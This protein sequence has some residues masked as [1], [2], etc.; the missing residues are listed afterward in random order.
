[1]STKALL[2][3]SYTNVST[4][5]AGEWNELNMVPSYI[6]GIKT[7]KILEEM[8]SDKLAALISGV[9]TP[10]ARARLFKFALQTLN[11]PDPNIDSS[12]LQ[13]FYEM[14]H[15]E[16]RGLLAVMALYPDRISFS[17]PITMSVNGGL[18]DIASA[19]G[20]ML[21]DDKDLWSNQLQLAKD[22]D[23]QPFVQLIY[24]RKHLV[25]GTSPMTGVFTGVDYSQIGADAGEVQWFR[26]GR[27]EDPTP[28]LNPEQ[29]QKLYL[30]IKNLNSH[31]DDF[32]TNINAQRG[33]KKRMEL[34][35]FKGM[36]RKWE[37][38]LRRKGGQLRDKG[39]VAQ[40]PNLEYP[41]S[42]LFESS[43]PVYLK[44]DFTFTYDNDGDY[45]LVGDVQ[46]LLSDD[47]FVVGW[48]EAADA[49]PKL[50]ES[51]VFYLKIDNLAT[52]GA[53]YF[54]LPLSEIGLDIFKNS[55][56]GLLGYGDNCNTRLSA[57]LN[58]AGSLAVS[59]VVEI[60]GQ[61]VELN[62]REYAVKWMTEQ[63]KVI[64][65]PNF[66]SENWKNYYLYTE[67]TS[68]AAQQFQAIFK[69]K[70]EFLRN[71]RGDFFTS[72]YQPAADEDNAPQVRQ[73]I[74]Y[75]AGQGEELHKY[76]IYAM[77]LAP[78][79]LSVTV[80]DNGKDAHAGYL[81]L[82]PQVVNDRTSLDAQGEAVVGIDFG[83]NNM[84]VYY[85]VDDGQ[86]EPI[87]FENYRTMLVGA[88]SRDL[89][90][91]AENHE[92]LFFSNYPTDNGQAK[93][94]LHEHDSRYNSY[95]ESEEVAGGVPVS[96]PNV[97]VKEMDERTIT[98]QAGTLHYNMKWLNDDKGLQ[99]KRAFLKSLWL[100]TCAY[101]YTKRLKPKQIVWSYPGAMMEAD[102]NE[103]AN[104][105]EELCKVT[106]I[107]GCRP[108]LPETLTTEAE[109]VCSFALSREFGL[110]ADKLF[111]GIDVGGSTSDILILA[112][113]PKNL[114][115]ATLF[116]ESSVR[117][118]AG[119]FFNAI[120]NSEKFREALNYYCQK[121]NKSK[122][123]V[124]NVE[125]MVREAPQK[126][127]YCLNS[128]FDQLKGLEDYE[129]FYSTINEKA[130]FVFTIPAYV[131]GLLLFYSGMLIG[132]TIKKE[133]LDQIKRIDILTF[134]KGGRLFH[135]LREPAGSMATNAY[136]RDCLN[137]G[138]RLMVDKELEVKYRDEIE[139][140]NK[141]EVAKGLV[142]PKAIEK[143]ASLNEKDICGEV[144]VNYLKED[145]STIVLNT[146]DELSGEF[147][148]D[149]MN[150][151]TFTGTKNFQVFMDVFCDFVSTKTKLYPGVADLREDIAD[152]RDRI[153][154]YVT[155]DY[156]Y[157]KA[158]KH[159][160]GEFP[161][162][163]PLIIAEGACFLKTIIKKIFV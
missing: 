148:A 26:N 51:A 83:S 46:K 62:T 156:E 55:L 68:D 58:D 15:G 18:Y 69:Q 98:T 113:D 38:E 160:G 159:Q 105:Y 97:L 19:F 129:N 149:N 77:T 12:G 157:K 1:M 142:Q 82:R 122:V 131:T 100:Q 112:Q 90:A 60:D 104:I 118:A 31:L 67:C 53:D 139:V 123:F 106:P 47:K 37:E 102:R 94:W 64:M 50:S 72:D 14:L 7:G 136:Y 86:A 134:G 29:L 23:A 34:S 119:V 130:K 128:V 108:K 158:L 57:R 115:K 11:A 151:L 161:Y 140:D 125:E 89:R 137:A 152:L 28:F 116:C 13:Q 92:L 147:F 107:V 144:D 36:S 114:N 110:S 101:L 132:N 87:K 3:K 33:E 150:K 40:Y 24:Y 17:K 48:A 80:K 155:E 133:Q 35:G 81:I 16:W 10:W 59:L 9:P 111:L 52:G 109:A 25:G 42:A 96:R 22:P 20:R 21:F 41:F 121:T 145:G 66:V 126:A 45:K 76:N 75:P 154:S 162:H 44:P 5:T 88:E 56:S 124:N 103:L 99:K 93:S 71:I 85:S 127:P 30:F 39:P 84:C 117:L 43:V 74:T 153:A 32:E 6:Q 120:I 54:S 49:R 27:F 143:G 141:A 63:R 8:S 65:W 79:G 138:L 95:N 91:V 70:G 61:Q 163:Q 146:D 73:L 2:I 78:A 135:W 4:G